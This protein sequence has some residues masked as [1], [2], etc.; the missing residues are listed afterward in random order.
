MCRRNDVRRHFIEP[1]LIISWDAGV[2]R[3]IV[4]EDT[5]GEPLSDAY[6]HISYPEAL[7]LLVQQAY[8][9]QILQD[10][11]IVHMDQHSGNLIAVLQERPM[12]SRWSFRD[13]SDGGSTI[14]IEALHPTR[15]LLK[16]YDFDL[17]VSRHLGPN[18]HLN[19]FCDRYGFCN[20]FDSQ[21]DG[22]MV[23]RQLKSLVHRAHPDGVAKLD[24][25]M[26]E[27]DRENT[28][29]INLLYAMNLAEGDREN[30]AALYQR[31]CSVSV[32]PTKVD[33][34][35]T[36]TT[37]LFF[38]HNLARLV[39]KEQKRF[40]DDSQPWYKKAWQ[41]WRESYDDEDDVY[42]GVIPL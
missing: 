8:I 40:M 16:V 12:Q 37:P 22:F 28:S 3:G 35:H 6:K 30:D 20:N 31:F 32:N 38:P 19:Q 5:G 33:C 27:M 2:S 10:I 7:T 41:R 4:T 1:L 26:A 24:A 15:Y 9:V 18:R 25:D 23:W 34:S 13:D 39:V 21:K 11:G 42:G 36:I 17:S 29:R 14:D